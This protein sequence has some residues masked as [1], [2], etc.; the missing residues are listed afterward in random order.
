MTQ[1]SVLGYHSRD[2][3]VRYTV[4]EWASTVDIV[5]KKYIQSF[6]KEKNSYELQETIRELFATVTQWQYISRIDCVPLSMVTEKKLHQEYGLI[7][8]IGHPIKINGVEYILVIL[9]FT[10]RPWD[11]NMTQQEKDNA[12]QTVSFETFYNYGINHP[13]G[14]NGISIFYS[15]HNPDT[16]FLYRDWDLGG[17]QW[18]ELSLKN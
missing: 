18:N 7:Q 10:P 16:I 13:F 9:A 6:P 5:L 11:E 8:T 15:D 2:G 12:N 1:R 17:T 4:L 14:E 3:I